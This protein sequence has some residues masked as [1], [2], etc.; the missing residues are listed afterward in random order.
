[1]STQTVTEIT[2]RPEPV[3]H[4]PFIDDLREPYGGDRHQ[5][6]STLRNASGPTSS[7]TSLSPTTTPV[8]P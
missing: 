5:S 3:V 6:A 2:R 1:M 4:D 8:T 7:S